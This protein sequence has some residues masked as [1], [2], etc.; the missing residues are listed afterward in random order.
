MFFGQYFLSLDDQRRLILPAAFQPMLV[1]GAFVFQ[2]FERN[3]IVLPQATFEAV[4]RQAG[5]LSITDPLA[6]L[7][8]RMTLGT[9]VALTFDAEGRAALPEDLCAFADLE[10][11]AVLIGQGNYLEIWAPASWSAQKLRLQDAEA[12]AGRFAALHLTLA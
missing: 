7:F 11:E 1:R 6:R 2:G 4:C 5:A 12:N 9:A 3:L 10:T 8:L